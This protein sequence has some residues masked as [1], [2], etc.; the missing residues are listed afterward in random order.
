VDFERLISWPVGF[1]VRHACI[2]MP[3]RPP[4]SAAKHGNGGIRP[5][6][7]HNLESVV[8]GGI[9]YRDCCRLFGGAPV[10][11]ST[12]VV[13]FPDGDVSVSSGTFGI[14]FGPGSQVASCGIATKQV[15]KVLGKKCE[16]IQV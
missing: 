5:D 12:L 2:S 11:W 10:A 6:G 9:G 14:S 1:C 16:T 4:Q 3:C 15:R 7:R 13:D 8:V